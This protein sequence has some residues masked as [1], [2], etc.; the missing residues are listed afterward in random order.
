[1]RNLSPR[2]PGTPRTAACVALRS[3]RPGRGRHHARPVRG[4]RAQEL[5]LRWSTR[6][7]AS[8]A[9]RS[10]RTTWPS[11]R[12]TPTR[13]TS[14][15]CSGRSAELSRA[16]PEPSAARRRARDCVRRAVH[17]ADD[18]QR[19]QRARQRGGE[20]ATRGP[21]DDGGGRQGRT[22][23]FGG[24]QVLRRSAHAPATR[25]CPTT[26]R[27]RC[28]ARGTRARPE[29]AGHR[30]RRGRRGQADPPVALGAAQHGSTTA[31][32]RGR[33]SRSHTAT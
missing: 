15:R 4:R 9:P 26:R 19:G 17:R 1:M 31:A 24:D 14:S 6:A 30:D 18:A 21:G 12:S 27:A 29:D 23:I 2:D 10:S 13:S 25:C 32:D 3:G 20:H 5:E 16:G 33:S 7:Q 28:G 11:S 22:A 8:A